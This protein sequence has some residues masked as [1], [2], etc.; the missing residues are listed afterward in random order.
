MKKVFVVLAII[1]ALISG[2][3]C[4]ISLACAQ[5]ESDV[6]IEYDLDGYKVKLTYD[7]V[8]EFGSGVYFAYEV[9]FDSEYYATIVDKEGLFEKLTYTFDVGGF[10]VESDVPHGKM[11]ASVAYESMTDYYVAN[12]IDGYEVS[13]EEENVKKGFFYNEYTSTFTTLFTN[14]KTEG[15]Y[16]NRLYTICQELGLQDQDILL[17]YVYGTPYDSKLITST[18]D[19]VTYSAS[20]RIYRHSFLM[21]V[22]EMNKEISIFQRSPNSTGW[23]LIAVAIG[24]VVISVPLTICIIKRKERT[25]D[26]RE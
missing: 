16:V 7:Y 9:T 8:V 20:S 18:A 6:L 2:I 22:D 23:Y 19:S 25:H 10:N 15:R 14:L 4:S 3:Q 13:E 5:E 17:E 1:V 12:G 21:T 11:I 24:L 26:G